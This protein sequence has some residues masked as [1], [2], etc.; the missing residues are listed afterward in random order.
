MPVPREYQ[1][2]RLARSL[3]TLLAFVRDLNI[4]CCPQ[5]DSG[6]EPMQIDDEGASS[7]TVDFTI[8]NPNFD[9]DAYASNFSGLAKIRRLM[10][11]AK[12]CPTLRVD[13]LK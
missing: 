3:Y 4:Y 6:V 12:H 2:V 8:E 13:S 10:F 9:L 7:D 5:M 1:Q 11:V